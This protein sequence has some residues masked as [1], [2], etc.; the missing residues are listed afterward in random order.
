[1]AER[2]PD[3]LVI[4]A[5][6]SGTTSLFHELAAHPS[7]GIPE[8]KEVA[9][10]VNPDVE[11]AAGRK[12]YA[13]FFRSVAD[14]AVVGEVAPQYTA[15]PRWTD[16]AER[17]R[18]LLGPAL[19]LVYMVRHPV[20]R[21]ASHV[22]HRR[23]PPDDDALRVPLPNGGFF[24]ADV[25]CYGHQIAPWLEHFGR[26]R[27]LVVPF[28]RYRAAP[29]EVRRSILT[30]LDV[31]PELGGPPGVHANAA[32]GRVPKPSWLRGM[33]RSRVY[34]AHVQPRLPRGLRAGVSR[35]ILPAVT[36]SQPPPI[37]LPAATRAE[38]H[39][40]LAPDIA[41]FHRLMGLTAPLWPDF[42]LDAE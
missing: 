36:P 32:A 26:C 42:P 25:S 34:R 13:A 19:K 28:E 24:E 14:R 17:A 15:A 33:L 9:Q 38:L 7:I 22:H 29:G 18:D 2:L 37:D 8:A 39:G 4:G 5:Y 10:L 40:A 6:K 12:R 23:R 1:M 41:R 27:I 21:A 30:F 31:D 11:T 16:A 20:E 3:F 35:R